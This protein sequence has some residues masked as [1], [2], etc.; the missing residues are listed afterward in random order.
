MGLL[1]VHAPDWHVSVCVQALPSLQVVPLAAV[2]LEHTPVEGLQVPATW[3]WSLAV[4]L[5]PV[6]LFVAG[7]I[8]MPEIVAA[9]RTPVNAMTYWPA[10]LAGMVK[11]SARALFPAPTVPMMSKLVR[12]LVPLMSTL[13]RRCFGSVQCVS[14]QC[15]RMVFDEPAT[16]PGKM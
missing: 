2:G 16:K 6:H 15:S 11:D 9:S 14:A 13:K 7:A 5:T 1:P 4:H 8:S 10:E 12:T 3:H